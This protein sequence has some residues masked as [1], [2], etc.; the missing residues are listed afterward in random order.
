MKYLFL[1]LLNISIA[2]AQQINLR[3]SIIDAQT[4]QP[5]PEATISIQ[6]KN[7][8]FPTDNKGRFD[9]NTDKITNTDSVVFSCIG[10][11]SKKV[12]AGNMQ[13]NSIIKLMPMVNMLQ[14]GVNSPKVGSKAKH[15]D[16]MSSHYPDFER[17]MF[18]HGSVKR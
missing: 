12:K 4:N 14:V 18:M 13:T 10:Y 8:F 5:I 7:L 6:A 9:I 17:A 11:Q 16:I 3:G 2:Q 15:D 1:L